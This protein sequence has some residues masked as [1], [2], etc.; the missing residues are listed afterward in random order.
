MV[1]FVDVVGWVCL[2]RDVLGKDGPRAGGGLIVLLGI[3]WGGRCCT[4]HGYWF[5]VAFWGSGK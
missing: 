5:G 3:D 2:G 4:A 1:G